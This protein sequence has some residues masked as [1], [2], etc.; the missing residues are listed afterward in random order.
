MICFRKAVSIA[1]RSI[2]TAISYL[3]EFDFRSSNRVAPGVNDGEPA[4]Q[5][6]HRSETTQSAGADLRLLP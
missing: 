6:P 3:S 2:F 1:L 4:D 5:N